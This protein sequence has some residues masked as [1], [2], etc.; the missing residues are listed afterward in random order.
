MSARSARS[1][2]R[3]F[4]PSGSGTRPASAR[5][6]LRAR[7]A[8]AA[9]R[10]RSASSQ[11]KGAPTGRIDTGRRSENLGKKMEMVRLKELWRSVGPPQPRSPHP[12][13]LPKLTETA[14][15]LGQ[16]LTVPASWTMRR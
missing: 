10:A 4:I 11:R 16:M 9:K 14:R 8:N 7:S 13:S 6:P 1:V 3:P 12:L 2:Q 5:V 15:G